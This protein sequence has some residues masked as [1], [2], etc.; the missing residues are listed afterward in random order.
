[1]ATMPDGREVDP[2]TYVYKRGDYGA[3]DAIELIEMV[4][5]TNCSKD[6]VHAERTMGPSRELYCELEL[7]AQVVAELPVPQWTPT[8]DGITCTARE[9]A[10]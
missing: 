2:A 5:E 10:P 8:P 6:C 4:E 3:G 7:P 9:V 1:M